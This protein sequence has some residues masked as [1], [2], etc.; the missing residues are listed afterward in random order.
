[1]SFIYPNYICVEQKFNILWSINDGSWG[2]YGLDPAYVKSYMTTKNN[3]N[4][5]YY[6]NNEN[7][8][9]K[10][11]YDNYEGVF[12]KKN[13][14]NLSKYQYRSS[15]DNKMFSHVLSNL[16]LKEQTNKYIIFQYSNIPNNDMPNNDML[17]NDMPDNTALDN[18]ITMEFKL[19][20]VDFDY[21]KSIDENTIKLNNIIKER[22]ELG[23]K[24]REQVLRENDIS[25]N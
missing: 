6:W 23:I 18:S 21:I 24:S 7:D 8:L 14:I 3:F 25:Y 20:F 5:F 17:N 15:N 22:Y 12:D 16:K 11:V 4:I 2:F 1:M 13:F 10:I 9:F 19:N